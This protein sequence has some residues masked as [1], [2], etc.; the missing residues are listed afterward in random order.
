MQDAGMTKNMTSLERKVSKPQ[1]KT[2]G[3]GSLKQWNL[4]H[5]RLC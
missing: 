2:G 5:Y 3:D 1:G 4:P